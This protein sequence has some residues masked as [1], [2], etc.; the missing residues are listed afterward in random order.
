MHIE[1]IYTGCLAQAS[2][3][4]ESEGEVAIIDPIREPKPYLKLAEERKS[5]IKYVFETHFH[6]DFVSGHLDL[7]DKTHATIVFGPHSR[8]AYPAHIAR[9]EEEFVLGKCKIKVLHT[10]GHTVESSCFLLLDEIGKP[11]ALFSGDTLFVGDVGRPDLMSGNKSKYELASMLYD[12]INDLKKLA[13]DVILFPGHGA[14]SACGKNLGIEKYSTLGAQKKFNYA[15]QEMAREKFIEAVTENLPTPPEYFF[16]DA[17]INLMGYRHFDEVLKL[18]SKPLTLTSFC[19][20][21][22]ESVLILDTREANDF[23]KGSIKNSINIGLNGDFAPWVG[24]LL[25]IEQ[26][27]VLISD[28]GKEEEAIT[29]LARI[30]FE[31]VKGFLEGGID[32]WRDAGFELET[33]DCIEA[34]DFRFFYESSEYIVI[35]LRR[36]AELKK[37][38]LRR[39]MH[40]SLETLMHHLGEFEKDKKYLLLCQ[41]GY[42]SMIAASI[43]KKYGVEHIINCKGGMNAIKQSDPELVEYT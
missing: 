38:H 42:R 26:A 2:Y 20:L 23:A 6:A 5:K 21:M 28:P 10:P 17:S 13:D 31:N 24:A 19:K 16:K 18:N 25:D 8:P 39:S 12:S 15:M 40:I 43:L 3:Y 41:G 35:D 30:G 34:D 1:Q 22:D 7:A 11:H 36:N 4:I 32:T 14:G 37:E 27:L 9:H 33:I 29:R